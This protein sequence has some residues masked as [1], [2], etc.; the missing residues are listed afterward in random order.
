[1]PHFFLRQ[2]NDGAI[3]QVLKDGEPHQE[4]VQLEQLYTI[5]TIYF[6]LASRN[7]E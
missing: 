3:E 1:M 6:R 2:S 5:V 4:A 7:I